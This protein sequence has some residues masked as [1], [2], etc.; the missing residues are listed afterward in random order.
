VTP[1]RARDRQTGREAE[2]ARTGSA[3]FV[4]HPSQ[5]VPGARVGSPGR[6]P[7]PPCRPSTALAPA[8]RPLA[9]SRRAAPA[10]A[11]PGVG[12]PHGRRAS[13]AGVSPTRRGGS[14]GGAGASGTG[15]A[16]PCRHAKSVRCIPT[17]GLGGGGGGRETP[18]PRPGRGPIGNPPAHAVR[19]RRCQVDMI[20]RGAASLS[21]CHSGTR[22][23]TTRWGR[24]WPRR[25]AGRIRR[26]ARRG[27]TDGMVGARRRGAPPRHPT[28]SRPGPVALPSRSQRTGMDGAPRRSARAPRPRGRRDVA[29]TGGGCP[30]GRASRL[31]V[32][33]AT[34]WGALGTA[35]SASCD[36]RG[37]SPERRGATTLGTGRRA[38][39][40][41]AV[42]ADE[43]LW[44]PAS[45]A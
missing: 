20:G 32:A 27:P 18:R 40:A 42:S 22:G 41:G 44:R 16:R 31:G 45:R 2:A 10:A 24:G 3:R 38:A 34:V 28:G 15:G 5:P 26:A 30:E 21:S 25:V 43:G 1:G 37:R 36:G 23:G 14:R 4:P 39:G 11:P 6:P 13:S 35:R 12:V 19:A 8:C 29:A 7:C 17:R 9:G 33:P